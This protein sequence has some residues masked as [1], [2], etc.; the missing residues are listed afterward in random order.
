MVLCGHDTSSTI[1]M[2]Q[3]E[4]EHGNLITQMLINPQGV[5]AGQTPTGMVAM[6]YF[7]DD[8]KSIDVE[9]YSTV[10]NMYYMTE[11]QFTIDIPEYKGAPAETTEA[12]TENAAPESTEAPTT[13]AAADAALPDTGTDTSGEQPVQKSAG[14]PL[15]AIGLIAALAVLGF[16]AG[17][18]LGKRR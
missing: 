12:P 3:T 8:G 18:W 10:R 6:L 17:M 11:N 14:L 9:Y 16:G 13:S 7:S 15:A 1:V 5:D 2:R 4:G